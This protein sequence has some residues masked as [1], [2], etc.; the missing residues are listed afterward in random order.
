MPQKLAAKKDLRKNLRRRVKNLAI[1]EKVK[2]AVKTLKKSLSDANIEARKK[3]LLDAYKVLDKA[4]S[5]NVIHPNKA[6][7]RKSRLALMLN[8]AAKIAAK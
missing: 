3:A 8:K 5:S 2:D 4:A 6:S 1:K 7:R